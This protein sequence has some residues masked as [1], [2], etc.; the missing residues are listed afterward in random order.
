[1]KNINLKF[2]NNFLWG[3]AT[4]SHQVEGDKHNDWTEWEKSARR[5]SY[6]KKS[7]LAD[8]YGLDNFISARACRHYHLFHD[9]FQTAKDLGHNSTRFS[10]AWSRVEPEE[11]K[12]NQAEID[13][14]VAKARKLRE[15]GME[16][17]VTLW[18]WPIPIWLRDIGGWEN[19]KTIEY[20]SRFVT[21][22]VEAMKD[23]VT[24]WITLNEP[25]IYAGASYLTSEW[26]PQKHNPIAY[27]KVTNNLIKAHKT[28]FTAIKNIQANALVGI[29][30]DNIY[31]E[32]YK[33]KLINK[34]LAHFADWWINFY[35]LNRI[36]NHQ[37]FIGVNYYF[38]NRINYGFGKNENRII[39]D[40][41]W[42]LYPQGI[43]NVLMDLKKYNKPI[44]I[45]ENGLADAE[46]R[47]RAWFI[48]E[49]L[50]AVHRAIEDGADV[51]GYLH[52]SLMD[53][54]EW[55]FGFW[56]RFGLIEVEYKNH[57]RRIRP[58]AYF[59]RDICLT[60][61]LTDKIYNDY[62]DLIEKVDE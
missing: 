47:K 53:N 8:Q 26:P 6:L 25:E 41:G 33:N 14:Y 32:P 24:Y 4:S 1:M 39:S 28:A 35:F 17:I 43:Y 34:L 12:F 2:P 21:K 55:A 49:S 61:G 15:L 45:T 9:D 52:W 50:K 57:E 44:I 18:H 59:Y 48:L 54:F 27:L 30:T 31:F 36:K 42:E 5:I 62:F 19:K 16:P 58:S 7:G 38:H 13:H 23:D 40:M 22:I 20:F 60:N 46:D 29:A 37:D 51:H 11:G 3:S 10:I 56:P